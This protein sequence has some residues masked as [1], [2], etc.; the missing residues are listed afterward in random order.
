MW[1][2]RKELEKIVRDRAACYMRA[3]RHAIR[4]RDWREA[5]CY[6][7]LMEYTIEDIVRKEEA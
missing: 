2:S 7:H 3:L 1:L 4:R 5:R 6:L